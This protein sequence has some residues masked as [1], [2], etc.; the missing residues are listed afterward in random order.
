V[1]IDRFQEAPLTARVIN[2]RGLVHHGLA[3]GHE[4][5]QEVAGIGILLQS[6]AKLSVGV[7]LV[8]FPLY[9]NDAFW[10]LRCEIPH[11]ANFFKI[12]VLGASRGF[13]LHL[14]HLW[15]WG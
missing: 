11:S 2:V 12:W 13:G 1:L 3:V 5:G 9:L 10:R 7:L 6:L 8:G 14:G 4:R 15:N